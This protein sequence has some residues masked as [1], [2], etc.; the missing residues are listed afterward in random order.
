MSSSELPDPPP[1]P[2]PP[3]S[4][5]DPSTAACSSSSNCG[6]MTGVL[7]ILVVA[8]MVALAANS[9]RSTNAIDLGRDYFPKLPEVSTSKGNGEPTPLPVVTGT[10]PGDQI[11]VEP[12]DGIQ[13]ISFDDARDNFNSAEDEFGATGES[14]YLFIDA[15]SR[16]LYEESHIPGAAWLYHYESDQLIDDL[17]PELEMAFFVIV[18]CNGGDCDDSLHLAADLSSLYGIPTENIY[19]YEG[20][21]NQWVENQMPVISGS[22]RR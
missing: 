12:D 2:N 6:L 16:D 8:S 14:I 17:R 22:E 13:R 11:P 20:G 3:P 19:V 21:L 9:V 10:D 15:R 4:S 1:S 5:S 18:Y 7:T